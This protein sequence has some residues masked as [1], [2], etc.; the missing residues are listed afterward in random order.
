MMFRF[1]QSFWNIYSI[2][3][4]FGEERRAIRQN[5]IDHDFDYIDTTLSRKV[6]KNRHKILNNFFKSLVKIKRGNPTHSSLKWPC[7]V[8]EKADDESNDFN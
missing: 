3:E 8:N 4:I 7:V 6:E 5:Y 2:V 1:D